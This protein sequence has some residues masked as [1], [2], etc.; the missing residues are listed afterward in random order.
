MGLLCQMLLVINWLP[1]PIMQVFNFKDT[2]FSITAFELG[3]DQ[4]LVKHLEGFSV[5]SPI[6]CGRDVWAGSN[7][8]CN[9]F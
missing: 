7:G 9:L 4:S 8:S 6:L 3:L 1:I 2:F 5:R